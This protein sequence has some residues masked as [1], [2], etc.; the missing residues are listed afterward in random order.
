MATPWEMQGNAL[1]HLW[2]MATPWE[3]QGNTGKC[4]VTPLGDGNCRE[5]QGKHREMHWYNSGWW[6]LHGKCR[7]MHWYTSSWWQ[8]QGTPSGCVCISLGNVGKCR[9]MQTLPCSMVMG[10][11][12]DGDGFWGCF[13][14]TG[15]VRVYDVPGEIWTWE[16]AWKLK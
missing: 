10:V 11:M 3:M 6:Q 7:E 4:S 15:S 9:E 2:V 12:C 14:P 1:V 8:L 16:T 13:S 5:T